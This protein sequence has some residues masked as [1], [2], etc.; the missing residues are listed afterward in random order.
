MPLK[1]P[2]GAATAD[3]PETAAVPAKARLAGS[4]VGQAGSRDA[5][6][7]LSKAMAELKAIAVQPLLQRAVD[8][9]R[10]EDFKA[11]ETWVQQALERD[12]RNGFGWYLLA[13]TRER[14]GDFAS[15]V[16]C[17]EAALQLIPEHAEV[18]NDLGRLA[19]RMGMKAHAEKLFRHFLARHKDHPEAI[20]NLGCALRDQG[21]YDEAIETLRPVMLAHPENVQ[22]W[23]TMGTVTAEQGDYANAAVFF[24]EALRLDPNF[25]R[26]RYNRGNAKLILG[27]P[28]GA[29]TDCEA[30]MPLCV[31]DDERQMMRLSR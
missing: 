24:E 23:N 16:T 11:A 7:Q 4:A 27:D 21:R 6:A 22:L 8:A 30:A 9:I 28:E 3:A 2:A 10:A 14:A 20:N 13:I 19:F 25:Y 18:A 31:S 15:S 29:L 17:Y 5:L 26:A 1:A 12:E